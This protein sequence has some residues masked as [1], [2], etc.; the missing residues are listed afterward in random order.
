MPQEQNAQQTGSE[1]DVKNATI[2]LL[3]NLAE[4]R[5]DI[6]GEHVGRSERILSFLTEEMINRKVYREILD[7]WDIKVFLQASWLYD[8][9]KAIIRDV[10]LMKPTALTREEFDEMKKHTVYGEMIIDRVR[11]IAG[12]NTFLAQA[13]IMA[14]THHEKWDGSGYP[15]ALA[16]TK[17]PLQGRLMGIVDVYDALITEKAHKKAFSPEEAAQI[18]RAGHGVYFD[19]ALTDLFLIAVRRLHK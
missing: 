12:D 8:V 16:G 3:C 1:L 9:G 10:I 19:P 11:E 17:I 4:Y 5:N 7:T 6:S 18:I 2:K 15:R 14:G 13:K